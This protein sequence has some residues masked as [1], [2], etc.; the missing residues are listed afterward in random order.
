MESL[1]K[2]QVTLTQKQLE[3]EKTIKEKLNELV[4][5]RE[6]NLKIDREKVK[7]KQ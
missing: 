1:K 6:N 3:Q 2:N 4:I 5:C 7:L